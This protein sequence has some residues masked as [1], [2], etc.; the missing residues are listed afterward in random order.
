[1]VAITARTLRQQINRH[2]AD[3]LAA[4]RSSVIIADGYYTL[5]DGSAIDIE[6]ILQAVRTDPIISP[7]QHG[8]VYREDLF[9]C[10]DYVLYLRNKVA[11]YIMGVA[12]HPLALG[13]ILT[14]KHAFNFCYEGQGTLHII[15]TQH[16]PDVVTTCEPAEFEKFLDMGAG[17]RIDLVYV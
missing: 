12:E 8:H 3:Y 7:S 11:L 2:L 13:C 10:D 17:N 1:M 6:W 15:N 16:T 4:G 9:D 14:R 5:V